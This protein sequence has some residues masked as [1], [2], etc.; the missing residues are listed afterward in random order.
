ML[1]GSR[2]TQRANNPLGVL[3]TVKGGLSDMPPA[4]P[5]VWRRNTLQDVV[6]HDGEWVGPLIRPADSLIWPMYEHSTS[7]LPYCLTN[8]KKVLIL[9][10]GTGS[11]VLLA[12]AAGL[13]PRLEWK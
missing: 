11:E 12:A 4:Q 5:D 1:P 2:I 3:E 9:G 13:V 6:F 10:A 7:L 8:P